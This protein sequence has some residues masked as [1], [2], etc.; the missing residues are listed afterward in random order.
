MV[1]RV[2]ITDALWSSRLSLA[3]R[4]IWL[5]SLAALLAHSGDSWFILAGLLAVFIGGDAFWKSWA[6]RMAI[7]IIAMAG[8]VLGIKFTFRRP[9]P[10][11]EWGAIYRK[12]DPHSFPSGHAARSALMA[13]LILAW[14]PTWLEIPLLVW[15]PLVSIARVALG[16][17]FLSDVVVGALVGIGAG[18]L[19]ISIM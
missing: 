12:T 17:H 13:V 7:V 10:T 18:L 3:N 19:A 15:A 14:G 16:V 6:L 5:K 11:G 4:P 8:I 2:L 1:D 9:R